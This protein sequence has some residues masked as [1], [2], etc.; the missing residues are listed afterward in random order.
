MISRHQPWI[1]STILM[2]VI[3]SAATVSISREAKAASPESIVSL[4]FED[5]SGSLYHFGQYDPW[6]WGIPTEGSPADPGPQGAGEGEKAWAT[7][8]SA[9]YDNGTSAYLYLPPINL[10]EYTT[11]EMRYL[12]WEDLV[13]SQ[14]EASE[15]GVQHRGDYCALELSDD[16]SSWDRIRIYN[17]TAS[18]SW[19]RETVDLSDYCSGTLYTRFHIQDEIDGLTDNGFYLDMVE[20]EGEPK[21]DVDIGV[22]EFFIPTV[23]P[24]KEL[25]RFSAR[26]SNS[27]RNIPPDSYVE[28]QFLD[29]TDT[30][31]KYRQ[32]SIPRED[33][34]LS[35]QWEPDEPGI[36]TVEITLVVNGSVEDSQSA[37]VKVVE[38]IYRDSGEDLYQGWNPQSSGGSSWNA[39]NIPIWNPSP[40]GG[41]AFHFGGPDQGADGTYGF[42]GSQ[43]A[44]L[45]SDWID[46]TGIRDNMIYIYTWYDF[47]GSSGSC[48]GYLEMKEEYGNWTLIEPRNRYDSYI[49]TDDAGP[50]AGTWAFTGSGGW[51]LKSFDISDVKSPSVKIRMVATSGPGGEGTGWFVDDIMIAGS[52]SSS[53][54][55]EPPPPIGGLIYQVSDEGEVEVAWNE[56]TVPDFMEYRMYLETETFSDVSELT[57]Q[58]RIRAIDYTSI[59]LEYLEPNLEYWLAVTA[60]DL[61]GNEY[62]SVDP[63]SF[64]PRTSSGNNKP[65]AKIT[66]MGGNKQRV[67]RED[68]MLSASGSFDPDGDELTYK[69]RMPNGKTRFGENVTWNADVAGEDLE[70]FLEVRDEWGLIGQDSVMITVVEDDDGELIVG[71][72]RDQ[73]IRFMLIFAVMALLLMFLI[74]VAVAMKKRS[75][76]NL[77]KRMEEAGFQASEIF[78]GDPGVVEEKR[79]SRVVDLTPVNKEAEVTEEEVKNLPPKPW[80]GKKRMVRVI[81]ECPHCGETFRRRVDKS[82]IKS[83]GD[84]EI[85]CPHCGKRDRIRT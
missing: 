36:Y 23:I 64:Y 18:A 16:N 19:N 43:N 15:T 9:G 4:D 84:L 52:G 68:I 59:M 66:V 44:T 17:S 8:L 27:G 48:G 41:E 83:G 32:L 20:V 31:V 53:G 85:K 7:S 2:V 1:I 74:I 79:A 13:P 11:A 62:K 37:T 63:I 24:I 76:L 25:S 60:V 42:V 12:Y 80:E 46:V 30:E 51:S 6:E 73:L 58:Y 67:M 47:S 14:D 65:V 69:W 81:L 3:A 28:F 22:E 39:G 82:V 35:V 33:S 29:F 71:L 55:T 38:P 56:T 10:L 21:P 57:P 34:P 5:D 40:S 78:G 70:V 45:E 26:I 49:D 72:E 54:D 61:Y 75:R 77:E 50:L